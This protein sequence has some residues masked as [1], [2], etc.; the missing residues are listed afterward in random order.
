MIRAALLLHLC[1]AADPY[2]ER[3]L[4]AARAADLARAKASFTEAGETASALQALATLYLIDGDVAKAVAARRK[5]KTID[6]QALP[7]LAVLFRDG[8]A[9]GGLGDVYWSGAFLLKKLD[10]TNVSDDV[11]FEGHLQLSTVLE[12]S[13]ALVEASEHVR[14]ASLLKPDD[15]RLRFRSAL[16]VPAVSSSQEAV[17]TTYRELENRIALLPETLETLDGISMPGTFY[18]VYLGFEDASLMTS[19]QRAYQRAHPPLKKQ[20]V[21]TTKKERLRIGFAGAYWK[22]HSVCKLLCGIVR[23]LA[24][25]PD[26][27]VVLFDATEE[28]DDWLTWTL[29]TGALHRPMDMTLSSRTQVQ[30]VDVLVYAELGMRARALTWAHARLAPVQVLFWGH[31]HTS[32]LPDSIDYFVSSDGF[33]PPNDDLSRRYAEQAVRFATP[34][35][36]FRRPQNL[37]APPISDGAAFRRQLNMTDTDPL[38]LC[39]QSLPKFHPAFDEVLLRL[40]SE[41]ARAKVVVTYDPKKALWLHVLQ[42]RLGHHPRIVFL[43]L[44]LGD[45]FFGLLRAATLLLDPFPFGG[46]V[47]TLEAFSVCRLAVTAPSLQSVVALAAGFYRRLNIADAPI[48]DSVDAYVK[49]AQELAADAAKRGALEAA[50]C[51]ADGNLFNDDESV[52]EWAAF[53]RRASSGAAPAPF[54]NTGSTTVSG[55][56]L[57]AAS[58][59]AVQAVLQ[60]AIW[61]VAGGTDVEILG[62]TAAAR[63]SGVDVSYRITSPDLAASRDVAERLADVAANPALFDRAIA[64][65]AAAAS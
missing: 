2:Y 40:V 22:R 10:E 35:I 27:E 3:G 16:L 49:R 30:D 54:S 38:Y 46:G 28:S 17:N 61:R 55:I 31:P 50:V 15:A 1:T 18:I 53:L 32:G 56:S 39:P 29:G 7:P 65:A 24:A 64:E 36:Y 11:A 52:E 26:F 47:T 57:A 42:G 21:A 8:D 19:I 37:Y 9:C 43:P 25:L 6:P 60:D 48:V 62:V 44:A 34:G 45:K 5:A 63:G 23:G 59:P 33:E 41:D 12:D 51:R 20:L 58:T 4:A 14:R 13:G